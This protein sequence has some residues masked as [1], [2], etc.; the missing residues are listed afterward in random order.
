MKK[1]ALLI[2]PGLSSPNC[3][4]YI[5][6]YQLIRDG[7]EKYMPNTM[8]D[9]LCWP[10]QTNKDNQIKG[11]FSI[12]NAV[13]YA[14]EYL[15]QLADYDCMLIARS[16]GCNIAT[17][18]LSNNPPPNINKVV[19]WGP[20]PFWLYYDMFV[21]NKKKNLQKAIETGLK[22]ID[23]V[24]P[25]AIPFEALFQKITC[26]LLIA[27]GTLDIY[28]PPTYLSY[29]QSITTEKKN[30]DFAVLNDCPHAV[31]PECAKANE[32]I[33]TIFTWLIK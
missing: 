22:V 33:E 29:L 1:K 13:E 12:L 8:T 7:A 27:T 16:S 31:T 6:V 28:C 19:F 9:I 30:L 3:E 14:R 2:F 17:H 20:P 24:A 23:N 11:E 5:P 4:K 10:G 21:I 25:T 18:L 15:S 32:F 26:D